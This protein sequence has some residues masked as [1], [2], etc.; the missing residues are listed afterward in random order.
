MDL[1]KNDYSQAILFEQIKTLNTSVYFILITYAMTATAFAYVMWDV[2]A[3]T[4]L[5]CWGGALSLVLL[6]RAYIHFKFN[7]ALTAENAR[8]YSYYIITALGITGLIWGIGA[9]MMFP[10]L[11]MGYQFFVLFIL[12]GIGAS[13][14]SSNTIYLQGLYIFF[15]AL[16][17][18]LAIRMLF[19]EDTLYLMMSSMVLVF[20]LSLYYFSKNLNKSLIETLRL[21]FENSDLVVQ[22]RIQKEEAEQANKAKSK[23]LA[24]ASH[25]LRQPLHALM[26]NVTILEERIGKG[27]NYPVISNIYNSVKSLE[28]LFNALLD[29]S[30]LDAGVVTPKPVHFKL[31]SIF[32][33]IKVDCRSYAE[34]KGLLFELPPTDVCLFTD[35]VLLERI[36]RN[37]T[38]NGIRYTQN[39]YVSLTVEEHP[40]LATL[41][42]IDTGIGISDEYISDI[43]EEF[44]QLDNP[45]R[46]RGKGLGLGLSIVKRLCDLLGCRVQVESAPDKGSMFY[47]T[48]PLGKPELAPEQ[49]DSE[50]NY[51]PKPLG[52]FVVIIDDE[53]SIRDG[54]HNLLESWQCKVLA[55]A[56]EEEAIDKL[57]EYEYAPDVLLVDYRLRQNKTGI[58]AIVAINALFNAS[59]PALVI[60]GDTASD[61]LKEAEE[62]GYQLLH[63]PLHPSNLRVFLQKIP[64]S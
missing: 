24:A 48:V 14:F 45:E 32:N 12:A 4:L 46:D 57:K 37:L 36:I 29:I 40:G 49:I 22:L 7:P 56:S 23:F 2:V 10:S 43:F 55:F 62:S 28:S 42:V 59:I 60:T 53:K 6:I 27:E 5:Y 58:E 13:A 54:L 3:P 41:K 21:R 26:L 15:P 25:D 1:V 64:V 61:R 51:T 35:P 47:F 16:L 17:F 44:V 52:H 11:E 63:K 38:S 39:G 19:M 8:Q 9:M 50:V 30:K 31:Q 20:T 33:N 18:P 34:D